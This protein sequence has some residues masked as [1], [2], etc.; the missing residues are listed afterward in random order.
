MPTLSLLHHRLDLRAHLRRQVLHVLGRVGRLLA[1]DLALAPD[2]PQARLDRRCGLRLRGR[3]RDDQ[4]RQ[5]QG[6]TCDA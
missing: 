6:K 3:E 1:V 4:R 5:G 2:L